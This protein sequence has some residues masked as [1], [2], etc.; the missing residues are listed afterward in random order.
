MKVE[1]TTFFCPFSRNFHPLLFHCGRL[2]DPSRPE[3][4]P[5]PISQTQDPQKAKVKLNFPTT[6]LR[7]QKGGALALMLQRLVVARVAAGTCLSVRHPAAARE[8]RGRAAARP[9]LCPPPPQRSLPVPHAI[10]LPAGSEPSCPHSAGS[11]GSRQQTP[12]R[13][14]S[15]KKPPKHQLETGASRAPQLRISLTPFSP[16]GLANWHL[17]FPLLRSPP[18]QETQLRKLESPPILPPNLLRLVP[19]FPRPTSGFPSE[20]SPRREPLKK[21]FRLQ[22]KDAADANSGLGS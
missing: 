11:A 9:G 18:P 19:S 12:G 1:Q 7:R 16:R 3:E 10:H 14:T 15:S 20:C 22:R 17:P 13:I 6:L 2:Q 4:Q 21:R 8:P 5:Q